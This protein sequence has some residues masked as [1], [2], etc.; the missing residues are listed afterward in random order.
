MANK[1]LFKPLEFFHGPAIGVLGIMAFD[2]ALWQDAFIFLLDV[3]IKRDQI[4]RY[5]ILKFVFTN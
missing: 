3:V 5:S 4:T 2:Y 1:A